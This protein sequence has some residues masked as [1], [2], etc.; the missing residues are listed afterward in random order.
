MTRI[1]AGK[2]VWA[3]GGSRATPPEMQDLIARIAARHGGPVVHGGAPGADRA[4]TRLITDP[5][6][7][8]IYLNGPADLR[9]PDP[10]TAGGRA[11]NAREM[12]GWQEA[13]RI[14]AQFEDPYR[15]GSRTYNARNVMVLLGPQL[16]TPRER[17]VVWTPGGMEAGGTG[18]AIRV[19]N[20]Y[21]IPVRNLGNPATQVAAER[22][23]E[24]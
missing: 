21:G 4:A 16:D 14:A 18:H 1:Y 10:I 20:H 7:M 9:G 22:W 12:P 5:K 8:S 15:P 17:L 24:P 19:A 2:G 6:L 13:L 11:F 23:L 3:F